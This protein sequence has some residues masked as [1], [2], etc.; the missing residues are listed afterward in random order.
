MNVL[1]S[2]LTR[3]MTESTHDLVV[4]DRDGKQW[5]R[6]PWA[7]VHARAE[8]VAARILDRTGTAGS[9]WS[10]STTVELIAA[11]QGAWL[12]GRAVSILPGP[13]RG[14]DVS[15]NGPSRP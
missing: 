14:A 10:V 12:A 9:A 8:N 13:V 5:T 1:A 15:H 7:E 3:A 6:H 2:A 11:I 4:L